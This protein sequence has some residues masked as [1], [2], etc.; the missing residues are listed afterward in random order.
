MRNDGRKVQK[1][2]NC[3]H[4]FLL[5]VLVL[6][7]LAAS[8]YLGDTVGLSDNGDFKRVIAP[9]RISYG[10][11][12]REAFVFTDRFK[13]S[14]EGK[15]EFER[16]YNALFT[17]AQPYVTTQHIFIKTSTLLN[18]FHNA[19]KGTDPS[20]YRIQWLGVLYCIFLTVSLC[21]IFI[22]V[23]LG[24]KWLDA[25]FFVLLIFIFCDVGYTAYF[26]SFYGEALQYTSFI[27]IF[28]CA[29]SMI[30]SSKGSILY[31]VLYYTG[32][33]L[34]MG[35]KFANIPLG[36][37]FALAGMSFILLN[38]SSS[39]FK[40][41]NVIGLSLALVMSMYF[42]IS[43]PEWMDE[44]TTYQAVFFGILKNSPTPEED[45]K[46]LGLPSYMIVLQN[47]NYYMQGHKLD[48]RSPEF[49]R[50]FYGS[51]SKFDV[52]KFYLKNP[53]RLWQKLDI[54]IK[55]SSHIRPVYLGNYD[56][57]HER[58]TKCNKFSIWSSFRL[59]LPL[60]NIYFI[61]AFFLAAF[62]ITILE[63][64]NAL[65]EK[66]GEHN[67]SINS[68]KTVAAIFYFALLVINI[69]NLLVPVISNGE[70]DI[71]KHMFGFV[72]GTDLMLLL[73]VIWLICK[74]VYILFK[75]KETNRSGKIISNTLLFL[76]ISLSA[77]FLLI[78]YSN[79][80]KRYKSLAYGAYVSFG[81][82][83]GRKLLWRVINTD[84]NGILLLSDE[85]VDFRAFDSEPR[86]GDKN[87]MKY[88]S[89]YWPECSLRKW[90]NG[91]FL[92]DFSAAETGLINNY[93]N[94]VLLSVYD[95]EKVEGGNNDFFWMHVPSLA[96]FGFDDAY[97]L[98]VND[99]VFL[100]DIK[101]LTEYLSDRAAAIK[102]D[103][104]Y[105]LETVYYA[106]SSM[107]RVVDEDGYIYMKDANADSIGVIPALYLKNTATIIDGTGTRKQPFK[108]G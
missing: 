13:L 91:E 6:I 45:L 29:V 48:I 56:L 79:K 100:L 15:G 54:S 86:D 37:I 67:E 60:D 1:V 17:L 59:K 71:A 24:H 68:R 39:L 77:V 40:A 32:V 84:E 34:F 104:S 11:E 95:K 31:C 94:K 35:S 106:N 70:A 57:R 83:N 105:W 50:D 30:F 90:L 49:K 73:S 10:E 76:C 16:L 19:L 14:F 93:K 72:T 63:L 7:V 65:R 92:K 21:M 3:P 87:R 26:N 98:Y 108:V 66:G 18:L 9:N 64:T 102:R 103:Y 5:A 52:L 47:T 51:I 27:F 61:L 28:A 58:L 43:V 107:V 44:H 20:V 88:G 12:D 55:N 89:N 69:I 42:F 99:K 82:Y 81:E 8:L 74:L 96:A 75:L 36:V 2:E 38:K 62:S 101:Q 41:L 53:S 97:H 46:E 78:T 33:I 85:A 22:N 23:R 4:V 25:A 80:P